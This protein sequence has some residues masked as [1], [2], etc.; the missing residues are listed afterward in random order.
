MKP[1]SII[2]VVLIVLGVVGLVYGGITYTSHKNVVDMGELHL[3]VDQEERIP[4][5]PIGGAA[6]L[7]VGVVLLV[8]GRRQ[9]VRA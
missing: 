2:G 8:M 4:I 6:A 5:T 3:Q 7:A 1:I 9:L